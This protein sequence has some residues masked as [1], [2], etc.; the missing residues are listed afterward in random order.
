MA[1]HTYAKKLPEL[2]RFGEIISKSNGL[3]ESFKEKPAVH[4][5]WINGN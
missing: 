5:S 4:S 2:S 3:V 1:V